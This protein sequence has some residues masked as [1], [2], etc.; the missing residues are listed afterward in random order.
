VSKITKGNPGKAVDKSSQ[1][2]MEDKNQPSAGNKTPAKGTASAAKVAASRPEGLKK[3]SAPVRPASVKGTAKTVQKKSQ[4]S[5]EEKA[6][7]MEWDLAADKGKIN[8]DRSRILTE[9][10]KK[11]E[12]K[13]KAQMKMNL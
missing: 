7:T 8:D 12:A 1:L 6:V 2:K 9:L 5:K 10:E 3:K 4:P 11:T 13:K